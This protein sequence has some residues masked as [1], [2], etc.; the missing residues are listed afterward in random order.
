MGTRRSARLGSLSQQSSQQQQDGDDQQL[1]QLNLCGLD[2]VE[3]YD[4]P[5]SQTETDM[6]DNESQPGTPRARGGKKR[7]HRILRERDALLLEQEIP[8]ETTIRQ[9]TGLDAIVEEKEG[10]EEEE[11]EERI[12]GGDNN[13]IAVTIDSVEENAKKKTKTRKATA[14][15]T[16]E[17]DAEDTDNTTS[18][19]QSTTKR[20]R[21]RTLKNKKIK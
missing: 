2:D 8:I 12:G 21:V 6:S 16:L 13:N 9:Q 1:V 11:E 20:Q 4:A 14:D 5:L 10:Q 18:S 19:Q 17:S 3:R 15:A 7:Q